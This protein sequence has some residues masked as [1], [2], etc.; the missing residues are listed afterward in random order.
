M[1]LIAHVTDEMI[2]IN[3]VVSVSLQFGGEQQTL[4]CGSMSDE[5]EVRYGVPL[6]TGEHNKSYI[7]CRRIKLVSDGETLFVADILQEFSLRKGLY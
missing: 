3:E 6:P 2:H 7:R 1:I 5:S 4:V